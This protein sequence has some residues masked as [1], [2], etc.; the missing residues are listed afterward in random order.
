[1]VHYRRNKI[2]GGYY[3]FTVTL[4]NRKSKMLME[5]IDLLREAVYM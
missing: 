3:F 2:S 1:M 5:H 4:Q